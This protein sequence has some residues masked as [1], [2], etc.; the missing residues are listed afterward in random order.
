MQNITTQNLIQ[1]SEID[2]QNFEEALQVQKA[3][4]PDN[5][6]QWDKETW[7][8]A[9]LMFFPFFNKN[10]MKEGV[11]E[12]R[13]NTLFGWHDDFLNFEMVLGQVGL[14]FQLKQCYFDRLSPIGKKLWFDIITADVNALISSSIAPS[15]LFSWRDKDP[16]EVLDD[17]ESSPCEFVNTNST[18]S[19]ALFQNIQNTFEKNL[20]KES[21]LR[22]DEQGRTLLHYAAALGITD[23]CLSFSSQDYLKKD[24]KGRTP[25]EYAICFKQQE[26]VLKILS[27]QK[28]SEPVIESSG[29]NLTKLAIHFHLFDVVAVLIEQESVLKEITTNNNAIFTEIARAGQ[30]LLLKKLR[31]HPEILNLIKISGDETLQALVVGACIDT[32]K[33]LFEQ[34]NI[35]PDYNAVR[36]AIFHNQSAILQLFEEKFNSIEAYFKECTLEA[37]DCLISRATPEVSSYLLQNEEVKKQLV[38]NKSRLMYQLLDDERFDILPTLISHGVIDLNIK[39]PPP[40]ELDIVPRHLVDNEWH[41]L[42]DTPFIVREEQNKYSIWGFNGT[43]WQFTSLKHPAPVWWGRNNDTLIS[44][45]NLGD[46]LFN[47]IHQSHVFPVHFL[48]Y[49]LTQHML[50]SFEARKALIFCLMRGGANIHSNSLELPHLEEFKEHFETSSQ[51]IFLLQA[52]LNKKSDEKENLSKVKFSYCLQ[53]LGQFSE[54]TSQHGL[55]QQLKDQVDLALCSNEPLKKIIANSEQTKEKAFS[56]FSSMFCLGKN[57]QHMK[58]PSYLKKIIFLKSIGITSDSSTAAEVLDN[59]S[60]ERILMKL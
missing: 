40:H 49:I 60:V 27:S 17:L 43:C 21:D 56:F 24:Y 18:L 13:K 1:L 55:S 46:N 25:I 44:P 42:S 53:R 2:F 22:Q 12:L 59:D 29:V 47:E 35:I 51:S 37:L 16:F 57:N 36:L 41:P 30:H 58:I 9:I 50:T 52:L 33:F 26:C 5:F 7:E 23:I 38:F 6:L 10:F 14:F 28:I 4:L 20:S 19:R 11:A 8:K 15:Q 48:V 34:H 54:K 32:L 3:I 39:I 31:N 45:I